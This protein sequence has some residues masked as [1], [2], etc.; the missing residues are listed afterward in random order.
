M[1]SHLKTTASAPKALGMERLCILWLWGLQFR[2]SSLGLEGFLHE[3]LKASL[4]LVR[5]PFGEVGLWFSGLGF[6]MLGVGGFRV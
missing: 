2:V 3:M 5:S 6:R 4:R 1:S